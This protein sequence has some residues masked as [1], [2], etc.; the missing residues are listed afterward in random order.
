MAKKVLPRTGFR[1]APLSPVSLMEICRGMERVSAPAGYALTLEQG[2]NTM[3]I[4]VV[5]FFLAL[6]GCAGSSGGFSDMGDREIQLRLNLV[7]TYI[8][9]S[10]PQ[11]A[12]QE[13]QGM[14]AAG[15]HLSRYQFDLAMTY[16]A[17]GEMEK[18][19]DAF[20]AAVAI[21]DTFAEAWNN[22]GKIQEVLGDDEGAEKSYRKAT[23]ILTYVTPEFAAT[24]LAS[25]L[26]RQGRT[27]G[28]EEFARKA[29]VRNWRYM[30]A[31]KILAE[32]LNARNAFDEAEAV[33]QRGLDADLNNYALMLALGEQRL[34]AGKTLQALELFQRIITQ[35][36]NSDEAK[37][38]RDY[39]E[40]LQ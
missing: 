8:N 7:E 22:L 4:L 11:L 5:L 27:A 39:L 18:A 3:R 20:A 32:A 21:D 31:Y 36:P 2:K 6:T 1:G 28:A 33:L 16:L 9:N 40:L 12:L 15:R 30:P 37:V 26:L 25:L 29:L 34:R 13:L 14:A 17:L 35:T 24:N 10:K 19:R 23:S 38:A